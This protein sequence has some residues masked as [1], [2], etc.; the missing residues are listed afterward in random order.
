MTAVAVEPTIQIRDARA[1]D[2][3]WL[4]LQ[5]R[6]FS[7]FFGTDKQLFTT[8]DDVR[9]RLPALLAMGPCYIAT[10]ADRLP[11]GFVAG[12]LA[13]HPYNPTIRVLSESFW[14]VEPAWRQTRAGLLLLNA[15]VAF[16]E[17]HADW[18]HF[19][20]EHQ[21]PVN[22]RCLTKRGFRLHERSYLREVAHA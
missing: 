7:R 2:T 1:S 10:N 22:E 20:L 12:M 13:P 19:T 4:V 21:S 15:F 5:L 3:D 18:I 8:A 6:A 17:A 14:W 11:I 9:E 16:G